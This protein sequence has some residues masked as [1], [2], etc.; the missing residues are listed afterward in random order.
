MEGCCTLYSRGCM[1]LFFFFFKT[2]V[3]RAETY[4]WRAVAEPYILEN[5]WLFFKTFV[6]RAETRIWRAVAGD[7]SCARA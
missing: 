7:T 6:A 5:V 3:E 2:L 4:I 1:P